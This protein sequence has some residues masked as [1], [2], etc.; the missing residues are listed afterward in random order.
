M[1][2]LLSL[3]VLVGCVAP[4]RNDSPVDNAWVKVW[5][6]EFDG[7]AG[8]PVDA[9]TWNHD[10]GGHGWGNDQLEYN[11]DRTANVFHDGEGRLVI[12]AQREA[13]EGNSFTSGRITT[14]GKAEFGP[15]RIE[16]RIRVPEGQGIWPAFWLLGEDFEE[17]G[18]PT[19]GE[20]D[21]LELRGSEPDTII[22]TVHGP[23]YNGGDGVGNGTQLAG[24][25]WSDDFHYYAVDIDPDHLVWWIDGERAH[26]VRP[27][28]LPA[29]TSWAFD[30]AFFLILNV[31]VG[32]RFV[33]APTAETDFPADMLVDWI[34]VYERAP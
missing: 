1:R 16:A 18:W 15:A 31:A 20:I 34:R 2:S 17:V 7:E 25:S 33:Q 13:Y 30:R 9:A 4:E 24:G 29:G 23:W 12:R 14:M 5:S 28:D 6:D 3:G 26:T 27:G 21:I 8:S 22:T 32:G 10:V 19:C 11:T